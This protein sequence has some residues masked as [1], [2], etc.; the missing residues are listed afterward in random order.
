MNRPLNHPSTPT[1]APTPVS[2]KSA[3]GVRRWALSMRSGRGA[4]HWSIAALSLVANL[5]VIFALVVLAIRAAV[6]LELRWD[7]FYYHIPF[8]ALRGGLGIPFELSDAVRDYYAGFPPLPH[9]VQGLLWRISGTINATG[10]VNY[11]AFSVFLYFCHRKLRAPVWLVALLS[12]TAP[13]VL[14]HATT[15]YVDLFGNSLLA[16]GVSSLAVM[17]LDDR[18]EDRSLLAW[19][20]AG[21][22]GAAWS[23]Y[24]LAPVVAVLFLA[25]LLAFRRR[26]GQRD[27]SRWLGVI[28]LA[29][30]VAGAPYLKNLLLFHNPFW[31]VRMPLIGDLLPYSLDV[32][33]ETRTAQRPPPLLHFSQSEL[34]FHSLLE[35]DHPREYPHRARWIIDQGNAWIAFRMGGF[36]NVA[37]QTAL[38]LLAW[39]SWLVKREKAPI[40]LGAM[41]ALL[42]LVAVL[43]QSHELRYYLFLPLVWA[44][45]I[46]HLFPKV[47]QSHPAVALGVLGMLVLQFGYI[48]YVNR[49]YYRIERVDYRAA[50]QSARVDGW[51][52]R[53]ESG[54]EYCAV[55][56]SPIE[57]I[58]TGPTMS[59]FRITARTRKELCPENS[60][61][62]TRP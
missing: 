62:I 22:I 7:T 58:L 16:I 52:S 20:L 50:A 53:L 25:F 27:R 32:V 46:G 15:S 54:R 38:G 43:P 61:V 36:W 41:L 47:R 44:A 11:L 13:L 12:L 33:A 8:S 17:F 26:T 51:W 19:G 23:K 39:L 40:L 55:N 45:L 37:V 34:F 21:L 2:P 30:I 57:I 31:P 9:I 28:G 18:F 59:E 48:S 24:Q 1:D 49:D 10:L 4:V 35:L 14:I 42:C 5:L 29:A 60:V 56:M 3:V 6:R